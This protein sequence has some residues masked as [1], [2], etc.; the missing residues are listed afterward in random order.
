[1]GMEENVDLDDESDDEEW[2]GDSQDS[3]G[4]LNVSNSKGIDLSKLLA[5]A[6]DYFDDAEEEDPDCKADP[7]YSLDIKQYLLNFLREFTAQ[8]YFNHFAPH[9]SPSEQQTLQSLATAA[10][11]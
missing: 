10:A 9:L 2:E 8:P 3:E 5:P 4:S 11:V 7:V 6:E 1:M